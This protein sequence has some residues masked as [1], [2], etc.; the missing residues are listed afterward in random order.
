LTFE[1]PS[2]LTIALDCAATRFL[3]LP[4]PTGFAIAI[5]PERFGLGQ[6]WM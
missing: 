4:L 2:E 3:G 6:P 5:E 1:K